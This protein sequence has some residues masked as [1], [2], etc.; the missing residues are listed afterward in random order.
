[1]L[2]AVKQLKMNVPVITEYALEHPCDKKI[3]ENYMVNEPT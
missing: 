1:M 2:T 3:K